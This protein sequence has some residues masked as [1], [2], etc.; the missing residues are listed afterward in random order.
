MIITIASFKGGT[1][2]ST[3]ALHCAEYLATR[4]GVGR[5][6]L[7]DGDP[8]HSCLNWAARS[9]G[10]HR[11]EVLD[12]DESPS[13]FDHMVIDTPAR[14]EADELLPL[15]QGSDLLLIPSTI[16]VFSLEATLQTLRSLPNLPQDKY[17][18][19][20]TFLPPR[21][22]TREN[23]A[24]AALADA[25]VPVLKAGIKQRVIHQDAALDGVTVNRLKGD[26]AKAGWAEIQALGKE[27][28]KGWGG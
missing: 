3:L 5:V 10:L 28:L 15:A 25:G 16:A 6:V 7:A 18:V 27:I 26:S 9:Q 8:N 13:D 12:G 11:F 14:T 21:G 1:S 23:D 19:V 2:K 17:A 22:K 24:R 20:L 4:R